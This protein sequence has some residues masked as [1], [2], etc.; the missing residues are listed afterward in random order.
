MLSL[1][2]QILASDTEWFLTLHSVCELGDC[3]VKVSTM[4][5]TLM[6]AV[7]MA[8]RLGVLIGMICRLRSSL[9]LENRP[10]SSIGK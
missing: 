7:I 2:Y 5:R 1:C 8:M 10:G 4:R 9:F 6:M 3:T